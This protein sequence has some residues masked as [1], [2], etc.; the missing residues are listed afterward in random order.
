MRQLKDLPND[1]GFLFTGLTKKYESRM[2]EVILKD[3][4]YTTRPD[5]SDLVGWETFEETRKKWEIYKKEIGL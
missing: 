5:F 2:Y 1:E 4:K 3:G